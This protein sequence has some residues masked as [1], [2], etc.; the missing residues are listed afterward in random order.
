MTDV[1][2]SST[3]TRSTTKDAATLLKQFRITDA[4]LDLVRQFGDKIRPKIDAFVDQFYVWLAEQPFKY[5]FFMDDA[6]VQEVRTQQTKYWHDFFDAKIDDDFV[7]TRRHIGRVHA[8]IELPL[9]IYMAAMN[10]C[11]ENCVDV[12]MADEEPGNER[13][14]TLLAIAK[15]MHFDEMITA[16]T[17][18][19]VT[20]EVMLEQSKSM[21]EMST[22]VT[23]IWDDILMLPLVGII[24]S[25]RALDITARVLEEIGRTQS[26]CF[27]LDISGVAIIDTAV[28][29][30]LIKITKACRLMGCE[31]LISG[32]SPAIA[33]T[34]VNLGIDVG[35][36][37]TTGNLRE[38]LKHAFD[39]VGM[40]VTE[41]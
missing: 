37:Q 11:L 17:Y 41:K 13:Q 1:I 40:T 19:Q 24:D 14:R 21:I 32:L 35:T 20:N 38:A 23:A 9:D 29:N 5:E 26:S 3:G 7:E 22:P 18:S 27:I 25:K 31:P 15:L 4:D 36:I 8:K 28:A 2:V 16:D 34:I 12:L 39:H 6:H 33:Q 10:N 30:Y